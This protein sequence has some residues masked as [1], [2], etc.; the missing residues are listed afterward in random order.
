MA[1]AW[2]EIVA[3]ISLGTAFACAA[4]ILFDEFALGHRQQM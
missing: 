4:V 2:A 1:P 3:W